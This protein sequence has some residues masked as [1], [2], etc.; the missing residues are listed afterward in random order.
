MKLDDIKVLQKAYMDLD[1]AKTIANSIKTD[2][3]HRSTLLKK[4]HPTNMEK[5]K[6]V[7]LLVNNIA[8][9]L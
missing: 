4:K 5:I 7:Q 1:L 3:K 9:K 2:F 8:S 6:Q